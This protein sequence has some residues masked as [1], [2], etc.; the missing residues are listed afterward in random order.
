MDFFFD[1]PFSEPNTFL[2]LYVLLYYVLF[3]KLHYK[4]YVATEGYSFGVSDQK[5][6]RKLFWISFVFV[7]T[8]WI[9]GDFFHYLERTRTFGPA[10]Y[11]SQEEV[12]NYLMGICGNSYLI[13]RFIV[14]GGAF[15]LYYWTLRRFKVNTQLALFVF[16]VMYMYLFA[17]ARASLAMAIYFF[18]LSFLCV[19][20]HRLKYIGYLF[21][22]SLI[23]I[24]YQFHHSISAAIAMT[25]LVFIPVNRCSITLFFVASPFLISLLTSY[26]Q[27][28][29][30]DQLGIDDDVI[31]RK[32]QGYTSKDVE[33]DSLR[34]LIMAYLQYATIYI[35]F[36]I[37]MWKV[38]YKKNNNI[39]TGIQNLIKVLMGIVF[40]A[41]GF[42]FLQLDYNAFFYRTLY[43][44]IIPMSI[45]IAYMRE[46]QLVSTNQYKLIIWVGFITLSINYLYSLYNT[47]LNTGIF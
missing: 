32:L 40:L 14:W 17:Y 27:L 11:F 28:A 23:I 18:G 26:F 36:A 33:A 44:S 46:N 16:F 42:L 34:G 9:S 31:N 25:I 1:Y 8:H 38:V 37:L 41:T 19:P 12:Y 43:M 30:D 47:Y 7:M 10:T 39:E 20:T 21:G 45:I 13:F 6:H 22:L 29:V 3:F 5:V 35:P 4:Y 24:S 2:T 15:I